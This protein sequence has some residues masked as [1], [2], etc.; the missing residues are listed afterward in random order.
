MMARSI[1]S[2]TRLDT[3]VR[4]HQSHDFP[5]PRTAAAYIGV[6]RFCAVFRVLQQL[7]LSDKFQP[8]RISKKLAR[9]WEIAAGLRVSQSFLSVL[10]IAPRQHFFSEARLFDDTPPV[11]GVLT[12]V[13][14]NTGH[15]I[16]SGVA[17]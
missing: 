17:A 4:D 14:S 16:N 8:L 12:L 6:E 5:L 9:A 1:S 15:E 13:C 7:D 10:Y 2:N 11:K 3:L